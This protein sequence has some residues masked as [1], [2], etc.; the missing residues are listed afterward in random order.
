M[1]EAA[2]SL[3][4]SVPGFVEDLTLVPVPPWWQNPWFMAAAALLLACLALAALRFV[5]WRRGRAPRPAPAAPAALASEPPELWALRRLE[6]LRAQQAEL[7]HYR[8]TI[9]CSLVLRRFIEA[10]FQ[11]P[12]LYQTTREFL[13]HARTSERLAAPHQ[14][15]LGQYLHFCD[16]VKFGR[17][18]MTSDEMNQMVDYAVQFVRL[19]AEA[20]AHAAPNAGPGAAPRTVA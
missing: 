4:N 12:V 19:C 2:S 8:L 20:G 10:R 6:E 7:G 5:R 3:T 17:R 15:G 9:E 13:E 1:S 18:S 16:R 11:L 14:A